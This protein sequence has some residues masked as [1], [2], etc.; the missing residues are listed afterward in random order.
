MPINVV[1]KTLERLIESKLTASTRILWHAGEPLTMGKTHFK[2]CLDVVNNNSK[3]IIEIEHLIQT[4]ATLIDDE[5]CEIFKQ[6]DVKVGVSL[7][8]PNYIHDRHRKSWTNQGTHV[9]VESGIELLKK[10]E[11]DFDIISVLTPYSLDYPREIFEYLVDSGCRSFGFNLEESDGHNESGIKI[12]HLEKYKRFMSEIF[13]LSLKI[14]RPRIC[15]EFAK[16]YQGLANLTLP[17]QKKLTLQT[18]PFGIISVDIKGNFSTFSPELLSPTL[19]SSND[20]ILGNVFEHSFIQRLETAKF[21]KIAGDIDQ[22][23]GMCSES[24]E[25]FNVCFGAPPS[26]KLIENGSFASTQTM[27]CTFTKKSLTNLMISLLENQVKE[28]NNA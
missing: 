25:Y 4:N 14:G 12:T 7:D 21:K 17:R 24:C 10:H 15:R 13:R 27:F 5:W 16:L 6:Y 3:S 18:R 28:V 1:K 2:K 22:G 11:I 20:F 23:V 26:N 19:E 9:K 8:G